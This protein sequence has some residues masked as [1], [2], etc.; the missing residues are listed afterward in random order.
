MEKPLYK[1]L[2]WDR[3]ARAGAAT[4][5]EWA[6]TL[7]GLLAVAFVSALA[8][9]GGFAGSRAFHRTL[10]GMR[11]AFGDGRVLW[12]SCLQPVACLCVEGPAL[13]AY[14]APGVPGRADL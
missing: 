4:L 3:S 2:F 10:M 14:R 5:A 11:P 8:R 7:W 13:G 6:S 1:S 12:A 9:G